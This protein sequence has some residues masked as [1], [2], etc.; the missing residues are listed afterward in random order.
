[1]TAACANERVTRQEMETVCSLCAAFGE[2]EQV[3]GEYVSKLVDSLE[4]ELPL[5][6]KE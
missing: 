2:V 3:S 4:K 1:M 6:G 5:P